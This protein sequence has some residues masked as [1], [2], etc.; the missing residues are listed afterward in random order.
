MNPQ[1]RSAVHSNRGQP[2]DS[3]SDDR[4]EWAQARWTDD[5]D[6]EDR[7][8]Q[9]ENAASRQTTSTNHWLCEARRG[10]GGDPGTQKA[11]GYGTRL[12]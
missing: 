9:R 6:D 5:E 8:V 4:G 3:D 7:N 10:R 2:T 12:R 1:G 11:S